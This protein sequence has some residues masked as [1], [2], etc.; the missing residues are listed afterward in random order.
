MGL[1][2]SF[3]SSK[4]WVQHVCPSCSRIFYAKQSNQS[5]VCG[6]RKCESYGKTVFSFSSPKHKRI[7][8]VQNTFLKFEEFFSKAGL[9]NQEPLKMD[10]GFNTDLVSAGVQIFS[11][12]FSGN[13]IP[14]SCE[15]F[16]SQPSIR[17]ISLSERSINSDYSTS[18][19]NICSEALLINEER[20]FELIDAWI[21]F[22]SSLGIHASRLNLVYREKEE[23]WG[24]G[25]FNSSQLFFLYI[26]EEIGEAS[27]IKDLP[28]GSNSTG[29]SDIGF[30][31]ERV[32]WASNWYSGSYF[33]LISNPGLPGDLTLHDTSRAIALLLVSGIEAGSSGAGARLRKLINFL[34]GKYSSADVLVVVMY[35]TKFWSLFYKI[36]VDYFLVE[37][38][39]QKEMESVKIR[40]L[41]SEFGVDE[42]NK[43]S[44][45]EL[46]NFLMYNRGIT[47]EQIICH[48]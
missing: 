9:K 13:L 1:L 30:G 7:N 46:V 48:L 34:I 24:F 21:G 4:G 47:Y 23:D 16:L 5:S 25:K 22:L 6:W 14:K 43:L 41:K 32:T 8:S 20:H 36:Q 42:R 26:G 18:F 37:F 44:L 10:Q 40:R 28:L 33:S 45:I 3:L 12:V 29:M 39:I 19:I 31:L 11:Q 15:Y 2:S 27:Y 17:K 38:L 35:Y